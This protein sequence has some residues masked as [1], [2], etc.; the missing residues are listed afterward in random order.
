MSDDECDLDVLVSL[1]DDNSNSGDVKQEDHTIDKSVGRVD[2]HGALSPTHS[3][4]PQ[5]ATEDEDCDIDSLAASLE[6]DGDFE[7]GAT[8]NK[9]TKNK[10]IPHLLTSS[11]DRNG[12]SQSQPVC[13]EISEPLQSQSSSDELCEPLL[14][15]SACDETSEQDED[16]DTDL[17][18]ELLNIQ[19]KMLELQS[20][21]KKR[22]KSKA[23]SKLSS[24]VMLEAAK[25]IDSKKIGEKSEGHHSLKVEGEQ[26][27]GPE[28]SQLR[29]KEQTVTQQVSQQIKDTENRKLSSHQPVCKIM[30]SDTY[31]GNGRQK[32][33]QDSIPSNIKDQHIREESF[34]NTLSPKSDSKSV[35]SNTRELTND[36]LEENP[37]FAS[38]DPG[39]ECKGTSGVFGDSDSDW[40]ELDGDLKPGLSE[41]GQV[42]HNLMKKADSQRVSTASLEDVKALRQ[43]ALKSK[44][45]KTGPFPSQEMVN[46]PHKNTSES[47]Q[48]ITDPFSGIRIINPK[49]SSMEM[50]Y[51]M[52]DRTLIKLSKIHLKLKSA[53]LQGNWVTIGVIVHKTEPRTSA[54]GKSFCIWRLS[55][56]DDC[57]Q[58]ISFFLF[59]EVFKQHWKNE[60]KS[61]VGILNPNKM[62][63][64]D[65]G[66]QD[67]A[68]T[69]NHPNQVM[70]MGYSQDL[71]KCA[72][73]SKAGKAC[74]N[75]INKEQGQFC[76]YHV[77]SAY[78]KTCA[79]RTELQGSSAVTPKN[80]VFGRRN[81]KDSLFFYGGETF[82]NTKRK[83]SQKDQVT[84]S[85]LQ[86]KQLQSQ[87]KFTTMSLHDLDPADKDK[88]R[89]LEQKK[90]DLVDLLA[91]PTVGS[92]NF[93][94]HLVKKE[95]PKEIE[96]SGGK[97]VEIQSISPAELLKQHKQ[98]MIRRRK[99]RQSALPSLESPQN[100]KDVTP[101]LARGGSI[102]GFISLDMSKKA[103][104]VSST[105][106]A[107][108]MAISKVKR[109]GGIQKEDPNAPLKRKRDSPESKQK[110]QERVLSNIVNKVDE[111][112][113][114]D[115]PPMKRS[116]LL[117]NIDEN[118]EEFKKLM[119]SRS[120]HTG[121][122]AQVEMEQQDRYFMELE[123]KEKYED[124]MQSTMSV[125]C[126]VFTCKNCS[127]TAMKLADKCKTERHMIIKSETSK[128]FFKC[129]HCGKRKI[130]IHKYPT[131]PCD[132]GE[133]SFQRT[134]MMEE[135]RGPQLPGE[136]LSL[137][138]DEV[139]YLGSMKQTVYLDI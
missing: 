103:K 54:S 51:K 31:A 20:Q 94:K 107:K 40:E 11:E 10:D 19:K 123:K 22:K 130:S 3:K 59:G 45:W 109:S 70:M 136:K 96:C 61:V 52:A 23:A 121:T 118:S 92:L 43:K 98:D 134:A 113:K 16:D 81:N 39:D 128:R 135:R 112:E 57:D 62:D 32:K 131:E 106:L 124:K 37:F 33:R 53:E 15:Q 14:S 83:A 137:R 86:A 77:Q 127:Y 125:K 1:L 60:V 132:C 101:R 88:L 56:L 47:Y 69:V 42:I 84:V 72:G 90:N 74:T 36:S 2:R 29:T 111:K 97:K 27:P 105:E 7:E 6:E 91:T 58:T 50:K 24:V 13:P 30:Q 76:V 67:M 120:K 64:A 102:D 12:P 89:Q 48:S 80:Q 71:G 73:V 129:K 104:P 34:S 122:L 108:L 100:H 119:K 85:K 46:P 99:S 8:G 55:D 82:T 17:Q 25:N 68:F 75:F 78:K 93:V 4:S 139:S 133:Y 38:S 28:I 110:M 79:K 116:K 35:L 49:I 26:T 115:E 18:A 41:S 65:K 117:G 138:G 63:K 126:T 66:Q 9:L 114:Q 87:G 95:N 44:S 21:L 5:P